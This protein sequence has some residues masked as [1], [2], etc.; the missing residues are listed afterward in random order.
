[1]VKCFSHRSPPWLSLLRGCFIILSSLGWPATVPGKAGQPGTESTISRVRALAQY[2]AVRTVKAVIV[3]LGPVAELI[4]PRRYISRPDGC[5]HLTEALYIIGEIEPEKIKPV[6]LFQYRWGPSFST[7]GAKQRC[8]P[9]LS[10]RDEDTFQDIGA[11]F[12]LAGRAEEQEAFVNLQQLRVTSPALAVEM[13]DDPEHAR[14]VG[15]ALALDDGHPLTERPY[16]VEVRWLLYQDRS[17]YE[18]PMVPVP[19]TTLGRATAPV[20]G[21]L[22]P[23]TRLAVQDEALASPIGVTAVPVF[24]QIVGEGRFTRPAAPDEDRPVSS[25]APHR[26][27]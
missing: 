11:T 2:Q 12:R 20:R 6:G 5:P 15:I 23:V 14:D 21:E 25:L 24:P 17:R 4:R 16:E 18:G 3:G 1:V 7:L 13:L 22:R 27:Q 26:A 8:S 9:S 10:P 19:V